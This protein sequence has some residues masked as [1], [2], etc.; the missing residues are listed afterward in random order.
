MNLLKHILYTCF[1]VG[2]L[3]SATAQM[4]MQ[5]G[6]PAEV[7]PGNL[8]IGGYVGDVSLLNGTYSSSYT[9]GTVTAPGGLKFT[10][11]ISY[12]STAVRGGTMP[13]L[14]GVP[15]GEG[16]DLN[17][18]KIT[19]HNAEYRKYDDLHN[20][21]ISAGAET[22]ASGGSVWPVSGDN[23]CDPSSAWTYAQYFNTSEIELEGDFFWHTP[24][25]SIPGVAS[26]RLVYKHRDLDMNYVFALQYF[27]RYIEAVYRRTGGWVVTVDDGTKYFFME[28][29][30]NYREPLNI[31]G[32]P[33]SIYPRTEVEAYYC[34]EITN[35]SNDFIEFKYTKFGEINKFKM[36]SQK[37]HLPL[38][39]SDRIN[40]IFKDDGEI[41][42]LFP[43]ASDLICTEIYAGR[44]LNELCNDNM[45]V[46]RSEK[47]ELRHKSK[48]IPTNSNLLDIN[49]TDVNRI[50]SL[51]SFQVVL[52]MG[53]IQPPPSDCT[54]PP[55]GGGGGGCAGCPS[56]NSVI[57]L[58]DLSLWKR[59][60]H[61]YSNEILEN[62]LYGGQIS[63]SNPYKIGGTTGMFYKEDLTGGSIGIG[64]G[65]PFKNGFVESPIISNNGSNLVL[66]P[67]EDYEIKTY[68]FSPTSD[69]KPATID[70]NIVSDKIDYSL[71]P[72][73]LCGGSNPMLDCK[74]ESTR[75]HTIFSTFGSPFKWHTFNNIG[76]QSQTEALLKTSNFFSA[77]GLYNSY[78]TGF[79]I[80]IGPGNAEIRHDAEETHI[81]YNNSPLTWAY[82][83]YTRYS[84]ADY[85]SSP[86]DYSYCNTLTLP[87][88]EHIIREANICQPIEH[89]AVGNTY[90]NSIYAQNGNCN[91][92]FSGRREYKVEPAPKNFGIGMPWFMFRY[93]YHAEPL[94]YKYWWNRAAQQSSYPY[95]PIGADAEY[96]QPSYL[97]KSSLQE[98]KLVRYAKNP[99]M[100]AEVN[101]Y[102][103]SVLNESNTIDDIW[104]LTS[105]VN[106]TYS[107]EQP[108][109][110]DTNPA[111]PC[112]LAT[113]YDHNLGVRNVYLLKSIEHKPINNAATPTNPSSF[114]DYTSVLASNSFVNTTASTWQS[115]GSTD[116]HAFLNNIYLLNKITEP[117]GKT[118]TLVYQEQPNA[119]LIAKDYGN[120][121]FYDKDYCVQKQNTPSIYEIQY[122]VKEKKIK[123]V[124]NTDKIWT[125][126]F[127]DV[128]PSLN[129][130]EA[131]GAHFQ[132]RID[133]SYQVGARV[134][135]V[136]EPALSV[137][138]RPYTVYINEVNNVR[139]FGKVIAEKSY[140][141][142]GQMLSWK[143]Y[144]YE[145]KAAFGG[146]F[147]RAD[148]V[149]T[150]DNAGMFST[151][152]YEPY[153]GSRGGTIDPNAPTGRSLS[154]SPGRMHVDSKL[155]NSKLLRF[156]NGS[157]AS[158]FIKKISDNTAEYHN[159]TTNNTS[160][161]STVVHTDYDYWDAD[162]KGQTTSTG[163]AKLFATVNVA[164]V[165]GKHN[166]EW[167]PSWQLF[168]STTTSSQLPGH[169]VIQ[170]NF[171][172]Y[173]LS[174]LKKYQHT[175]M[176]ASPGTDTTLWQTAAAN[177]RFRHAPRPMFNA[178]RF[179][180][181]NKVRSLSFQQYSRTETP[182]AP[183]VA[184]SSY[185]FYNADWAY[186][187]F[188]CEAAY[189]PQISLHSDAPTPCPTNYIPPTSI[190][191]CSLWIW[192][193]RP[194]NPLLDWLPKSY[195]DYDLII[196][197]EWYGYR[198]ASTATC[199]PGARDRYVSTNIHNP[200]YPNEV[201]YLLS[202]PQVNP[203][204]G[205]PPPTYRLANNGGG[206]NTIN[207]VY[208][209]G[210][211]APKIFGKHVAADYIQAG[212]DYILDFTTQTVNGKKETVPEYITTPSSNI[213]VTQKYWAHNQFGFPERSCDAKG[214]VT[215]YEYEKLSVLSTAYCGLQVT[216]TTSTTYPND[217]TFQIYA[218]NIGLPSSVTVGSGLPDSLISFYHYNPNGTIAS[219]A[220]PN[221]NKLKYQYD[222]FNRPIAFIHND[223][224]LSKNQYNIWDNDLSADFNQRTNQNY[225]TTRTYA[226]DVQYTEGR[227][228]ID[229]LGREAGTWLHN[230][231]DPTRH[232]LSGAVE[233]DKWDRTTKAYKP[234]VVI[235]NT[236]VNTWLAANFAGAN[237]E[238]VAQT[239]Y[240]STPRSRVLKSAKYGESL[241]TARTVNSNYCTL[242]GGTLST[243][244]GLTAT[245]ANELM[246]VGTQTGTS[247]QNK[248]LFFKTTITDE[249]GKQ[250]TE[251]TNAAGQKVAS[252]S[253]VDGNNILTLFQ[254]NSQ[255]SLVK[256]I[257]PNKLATTYK[258]NLMGWAYEQ[259]TTDAGIVRRYF[260]VEGKPLYEE[261]EVMRNNKQVRYFHYD[262]FGRMTEQGIRF[263][264]VVDL[265]NQVY[266]TTFGLDAAHS[267]ATNRTSNTTFEDGWAGTPSQLSY[268]P[269]KQWAYHEVA[270]GT[271]NFTAAVDNTFDPSENFYTKGQLTFTAAFN[272][273]GLP[274][275]YRWLGYDARGRLNRELLQSEPFNGIRGNEDGL[276]TRIDYPEYTRTGNL[277]HQIIDLAADGRPD[278]HHRYSYDGFNRLI[279]NYTGYDENSMHKVAAYEY[280]DAR[281][282]MERTR[283]YQTDTEGT[284]DVEIDKI[285][286]AYDTR[287][288]LTSIDAKNFDWQL[289]YDGNI[290]CKETTENYNGNINATRGSW[291]IN[292]FSNRV[293]ITN[294]QQFGQTNAIDNTLYCYTYDALNRLVAADAT[295][296]G[297]KTTI[298]HNDKIGDTQYL[299]DAV[300]NMKKL[301]RY[302]L[303]TTGNAPTEQK[304]IYNYSTINNQLNRVVATTQAYFNPLPPITPPTVTENYDYAYDENGN[305]EGDTH[306]HL[307]N[308][309]Y[310]RANLPVYMEKDG[311]VIQ[312]AYGVSDSRTSKLI[313][314]D[315]GE[316]AKEYYLRSSTGTDLA[317]LDM[318]KNL[319]TWYIHG[320]SR[321]AHFE[322]T[323]TL[324]A[325]W[326]TE[327]KAAASPDPSR[328]GET[329][330]S[331]SA[332]TLRDSTKR[333]SAAISPLREGQGEA[334]G[335][336]LVFYNYDHL[337]NTRLTYT[338]TVKLGDEP[339]QEQY[340]YTAEGIY[341]YDPYGKILRSFIKSSSFG[342]VRGGEKY[343]T[344]GHERD[345]E[346][347][348]DYRGARFY[349]SEVVRFLSLDPLAAKFA[350]W[351]AYNY[352]L[353]NPIVFVDKDGKQPTDIIVL[354]ASDHVGPGIGHAAVLI[355]DDLHG[356]TLYSKGGTH[357]SSGA[358]GRSNK[359]QQA[360]IEQFRSLEDFANSTFG[361]SGGNIEEDGTALYDGAY[362]IKTDAATDEKMKVA[363]EATVKSWYNVLACS[364]IDVASDALKAGGLNDGTVTV[365]Q[366]F[367]THTSISP[368]PNLRFADIKKNNVG[369]D[370]ST[371]IKPS[372]NNLQLIKKQYETKNQIA[373]QKREEQQRKRELHNEKMRQRVQEMRESGMLEYGFQ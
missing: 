196:G 281:G 88:I 221:G 222:G 101:H 210:Y 102:K 25:L 263:L 274:I 124:S 290:P 373:K 73:P 114:F 209:G 285:D 213:V 358:S 308:I 165:N 353:G 214:L 310:A 330:G 337:G 169:K 97:N 351:S 142:A 53:G 41:G 163:Y 275:E 6:T 99:Y 361:A 256:V 367:E 132:S 30:T 261:T 315:D 179:C 333:I 205:L 220:D 17:I 181:D 90:N 148:F 158:Y 370:V 305:L 200:D 270:R 24:T 84:D 279:T 115:I 206:N 355:G 246:H 60:G 147:S 188:S 40:R 191:P 45:S 258:Y 195:V 126:E 49:C 9:L 250:A 260:D 192:Q 170:E 242:R 8:Q 117:L 144:E 92:P 133:R 332:D 95:C 67:Y 18:P 134:V 152:D 232:V 338:A 288:R 241:T 3:S 316:V 303:P 216:S 64:G 291:L 48:S 313:K 331:T 194:T 364:C 161:D 119:L 155:T 352:V 235:G 184:S 69:M 203:G 312:Y 271:G 207:E 51:Y 238:N 304:L 28:G 22:T 10:A 199:V 286:Y 215:R 70:I 151:Y 300:G 86:L 187:N 360:G 129:E 150:A 68:I 75:S 23:D 368:I 180:F 299:Y 255:G 211:R 63:P 282:V 309:A 182:Y 108:Q 171:P 366:S 100:L 233:R 268:V 122:T 202:F 225:V 4:M 257:H 58:T 320:A 20:H 223:T 138:N 157:R 311:K 342:G 176:I 243:E 107:V 264:N 339:G 174:N 85:C 31:N 136:R 89:L 47:L 245:E 178:L 154:I 98:V 346:T 61:V 121:Q 292:N 354:S 77:P 349:D 39:A 287:T 56:P 226:N 160:I 183:P 149:P 172:Y 298:Q 35:T 273:A 262:A 276:L 143:R 137:G 340:T 334:L 219:I 347:D 208:E 164:P 266:F 173:D 50:D 185:Q 230:S 359:N 166:L 239:A 327:L 153:E 284:A 240:E 228:Y 248:F 120:W 130:S 27:D 2:S 112:A 43:R 156:D 111:S 106:L 26:G 127:T 227:A 118:T 109:W 201:L 168:S 33:S 103:L 54:P 297:I 296:T 175:Y 140:D 234:T 131:A 259:T 283:Y 236:D 162:H 272:T 71:T 293:D 247:V 294:T 139:L 319:L 65:I 135:T 317:T 146:Q 302:L 13:L 159:C 105:T 244:L 314:Q 269:E 36:Y 5:G 38:S 253:V 128:I 46:L 217:Y 350:A 110:K 280:D 341:D 265:P 197:D 193:T 16:W 249:D 189:Y 231:F 177:T 229:P 237:N 357:S 167:E 66:V 218:K 321:I 74:F 335:L 11:Q 15:Y 318:T 371:Q 79:R 295:M 369:T 55:P 57:D 94:H 82:R 267:I 362:R 21:Y 328:G 190:P 59:Y 42:T 277:M 96:N 93:H 186:K 289:S 224:L 343:L 32:E 345:T 326:F 125:Y 252:L 72:Q 87:G 34:T 113:D 14:S 198:N 212:A 329:R 123:D 322:H 372:Y 78:D 37:F 336:G 76:Y 141:G 325:G 62:E 1:C 356:W 204:T 19:L 80:Q 81:G 145:A 363:A 7:K 44:K 251:Y 306:K 365:T 116:P 104:T 29:K 307:Y 344:T 254:Y 12:N 83:A 348:L 323:G 52:Q 91:C 324:P 278:M 301:V